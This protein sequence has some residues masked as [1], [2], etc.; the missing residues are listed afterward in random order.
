[1]EL[2]NISLNPEFRAINEPLRA[3]GLELTENRRRLEKIHS[4]LLQLRT[5]HEG[6]SDWANYLNPAPDQSMR[7]ADLRSEALK[8]EARQQM[9]ERALVEG[10]QQVDI[11][12][13]KLSRKPCEQARPLV[14]A[15]VRKILA[16]LNQIDQANQSILAIQNSIESAGFKATLPPAVLSIESYGAAYRSYIEHHYPEVK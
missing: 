7:R 13:N 1:M 11:V 9:L 14:I 5:N 3:L 16:A 6:E 4:E 8:I 15:Q 12:R 10:N 2:T